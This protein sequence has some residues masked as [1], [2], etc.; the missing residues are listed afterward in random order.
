MARDLLKLRK[1]RV[2]ARRD[3]SSE[4]NTQMITRMPQ[5]SDF[6]NY[7]KHKTLLHYNTNVLVDKL[8]RKLKRESR[9]L[10]KSS[11]FVHELASYMVE[12]G[13]GCPL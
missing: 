12:N 8:R 2:A 6:R 11:R 9:F 5:S 7:F 10:S 4:Q 1:I 13:G 3:G